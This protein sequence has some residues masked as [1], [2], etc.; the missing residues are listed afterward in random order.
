MKNKKIIS[1]LIFFTIVLLFN[2]P[3]TLSNE[4]DDFPIHL[5]VW[6][7]NDSMLS[8]VNISIFDSLNN[9]ILKYPITSEEL[10]EDYY[11]KVMIINWN[12][13][14]RELFIKVAFNNSESLKDTA[15]FSQD[16][17]IN[18]K[19]KSISIKFDFKSKDSIIFLRR[20]LATIIYESSKDVI[21]QRDWI[22]SKNGEPEYKIINNLTQTIY[23]TNFANYFWGSV[24]IK[25][26]DYWIPYFRG[27]LCFSVAKYEP[28]QPGEFGYSFEGFFIGGSILFIH[29]EYRYEDYYSL[30]PITIGIPLANIEA[31][32]TTVN[33]REFYKLVDEFSI[34]E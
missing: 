32:I 4:D 14:N 9:I 3:N 31:N 29:G 34:D 30:T 22:P 18:G 8:Y 11:R 5:S 33:I 20:F 21:F 26:K 1:I 10:N 27:G 23:G 7:S 16:I 15:E 6:S 13:D 17:T 28:I 25:I 19:E 24:Y 12:R 2:I